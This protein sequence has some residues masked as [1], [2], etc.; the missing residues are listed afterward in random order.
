MCVCHSGPTADSTR[1]SSYQRT[2]GRCPCASRN[3]SLQ[4]RSMSCAV[5]YHIRLQHHRNELCD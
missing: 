3:G 2:S 1:D 5:S 4:E